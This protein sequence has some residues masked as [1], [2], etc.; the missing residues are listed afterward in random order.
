M[1]KKDVSDGHKM[2]VF[3][4]F[5]EMLGIIGGELDRLGIPYGMITGDIN[6]SARNRGEDDLKSGK[7]SVMLIIYSAGGVGLNLQSADRVI[8]FDPC[9]NSAVEEQATA[10]AY[11]KNQKHDV[12]SVHL[13]CDDTIEVRIAELQKKKSKLCGLVMNSRKLNKTEINALLE[14]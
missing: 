13:I 9:W 6:A 12:V 3:S 5:K 2:L 14:L 1:I 8:H 11:R 10:R 7:I 4:N